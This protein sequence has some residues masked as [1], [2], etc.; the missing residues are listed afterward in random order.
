MVDIN[1][2]LM[3]TPIHH[4]QDIIN[5]PSDVNEIMIREGH[6]NVSYVRSLYFDMGSIS[7]EVDETG[8]NTFTYDL[9]GC[10]VIADIFSDI[11]INVYVDNIKINPDDT[12]VAPCLTPYR[13]LVR[14]Y[15]PSFVTSFEL[16][17]KCYV[18]DSTTK[19]MLR[20]QDVTTGNVVYSRGEVRK[21]GEWQ[22]VTYKKVWATKH[23]KH[24][25]EG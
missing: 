2:F 14:F 12:C 5:D 15:I 23:S 10:D 8:K 25:K 3:C 22:H 11:P 16:C 13:C 17:M 9:S 21:E 24:L 4:I 20:L 19:K 6:N 7:L 18:F 1:N